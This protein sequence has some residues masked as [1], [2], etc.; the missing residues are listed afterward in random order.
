M[1]KEAKVAL[2][3]V[4]VA[5]AVMFAAPYVA[6]AITAPTT[7]TFAYDVYDITVNK[8]LKGPIGF[9][10]GVAGIVFGATQL[11]MGRIFQGVLPVLGGAL[12]LKAEDITSTL[13]LLI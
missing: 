12:L 8:M 5:W 6:H 4:L 7:G 2:F 9:V 11:F 3:T 1:R 10:G 13:G